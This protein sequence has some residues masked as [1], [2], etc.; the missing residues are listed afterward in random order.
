MPPPE[1]EW[2]V[3]R[4]EL[5]KRLF[6]DERASLRDAQGNLSNGAAT[7]ADYETIRSMF[8]LAYERL[9]AGMIIVREP[10]PPAQWN[11]EMREALRLQRDTGQPWRSIGGYNE[12]LME[13]DEVIQ[14]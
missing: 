8:R 14:D 11:A 3:K 9:K 2:A 5:V 6:S 12:Y 1:D 10:K 13:A 4:G 7:E